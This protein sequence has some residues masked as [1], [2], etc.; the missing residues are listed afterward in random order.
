M[1]F[2]W[3]KNLAV[4]LD[5]NPMLLYMIADSNKDVQKKFKMEGNNAIKKRKTGYKK[6]FYIAHPV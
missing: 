2:Q 5:I 4:H 3:M 6:N 1:L